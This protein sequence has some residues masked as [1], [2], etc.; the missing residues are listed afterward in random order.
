MP[1][2][3]FGLSSGALVVTISCSRSAMTRSGSGISA[4]FS[5]RAVSP[6]CLPFVSR[7]RSFMAARSSAVNPIEPPRY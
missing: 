7:A 5:R 6:S 1:Y 2:Q 4:T 3:V